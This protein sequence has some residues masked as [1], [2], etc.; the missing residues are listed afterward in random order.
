MTPELSRSRA[1]TLGVIALMG[2]VLAAIGLFAVGDRQELWHRHVRLDV[3]LPAAGG[4]D[5]GARVRVQGVNAGQ[6]EAL[7]QPERRGGEI[8]LRARLG[9]RFH[10]LLGR[11]AHANVVTEGLLGGK[12]LEIAPGTS[13][14]PLP[15]GVAIPGRVDNLMSD[16]RTLAQK[17]QAVMDDLGSI[18]QQ[19]RQIGARGDKLL[20]DLSQLSAATKGAVQEVELLTRDIREG[21]GP[22]GREVLMTLRQLQLTGLSIH[23]SIEAL[24]QMPLVGKYLDNSTKLL[25]RPNFFRSATVFKEEELFPPGRALFTPE[26][27]GRLNGWAQAQVP[28]LTKDAEIVIVAYQNGASDP[29]AADVLSQRQAEAV[30]TY[31]IDQFKIDRLGWLSSR[32][33]HAVGMGVRPAPGEP[34]TPPAPPLPAPPPPNRVEIVVF[35]PPG[36]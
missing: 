2:L 25:V 29:Q 6:V 36:A 19:A 22:L 12:V 9:Q 15:P 34:Q 16:L 20:E 8:T 18:T 7:L 28:K 23:Q 1:L 10:A 33:V 4:I 13:T 31:L 3:K 11:D 27:V 5:V 17:T 14:E 30:R 24:R 35:V 32:S 26:G 21:H